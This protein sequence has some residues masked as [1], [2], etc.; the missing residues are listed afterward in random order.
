[1][2]KITLI[3]LLFFLF[4]CSKDDDS[5]FKESDKKEEPEQ[6]DNSNV[7]EGKIILPD[8]SSFNNDDLSVVSFIETSSVNDGNYSI[9]TPNGEHNLTFVTNKS[10]EVLLL[11]YNYPDQAISDISPEST[12]IALAMNLPIMSTISDQAKIEF[13]S[14]LKQDINFPIVVE[15]MEKIIA[16][17]ISPLS[18]EQPQFLS[19]LSKL[20][21]S[22]STNKKSNSKSALTR[23]PV[24]LLFGSNSITFQNSGKLYD[25][26]IGVYKD[27]SRIKYLELDRI[28]FLANST[29]EAI[30]IANNLENNDLG[31]TINVVEEKYTFVDEGEYE[32]KIRTGFGTDLSF[33]SNQARID[34]IS[35]WSLDVLLTILPLKGKAECIQ[36]ILRETRSYT[37][38]A[39]E[40]KTIVTA[41]DGITLVI[42]I[43]KSMVD[44]IK[45][46]LQCFSKNPESLKF[47]SMAKKLLGWTSWVSRIGTGGNLVLGATQWAYDN[48]S[49]D[50]CYEFK[51]NKLEE[52]EKDQTLSEWLLDGIKIVGED[53]AI[54]SNCK[55]ENKS[56]YSEDCDNETNTSITNDCDPSRLFS[57][58]SNGTINSENG[59]NYDSFIG[60]YKINDNSVHIEIELTYSI[61]VNTFNSK[62]KSTLIYKGVKNLEDDF[63]I[64]EYDAIHDS[65]AT[66]IR[67]IYGDDNCSRTSNGTIT[68]TYVMRKKK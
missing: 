10:D 62:G 31:K 27:G 64:L 6:V 39:I 16:Q 41:S 18:T 67:D 68:G 13:I 65:N 56:I 49:M 20:F 26:S 17:G 19:S 60:T 2:K 28:K 47:I 35:K 24:N 63:I 12:V 3:A 55:N 58:N 53:E 21:E 66:G 9:K 40:G 25:T 29:S 23:E 15:N 43:S 33:E 50:L 51:D 38:T 14:K 8:G 52:C 5:N 32:I 36:D 7:V 42:D 61:S 4:T 46:N 44:L 22:I 34:N 1:M 59:T 11:K 48:S 45:A 57:F 54:P 37:V 30:N